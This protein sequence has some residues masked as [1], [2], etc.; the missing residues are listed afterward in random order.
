MRQFQIELQRTAYVLQR[1]VVTVS[2]TDFSDA[3][4]AASERADTADLWETREVISASDEAAV[5]VVELG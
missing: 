5:D 4:F 2:A 1:A 3:L